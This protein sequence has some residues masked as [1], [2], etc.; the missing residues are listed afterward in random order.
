VA[1]AGAVPY[2]AHY[3]CSDTIFGGPLHART[4]SGRRESGF[5]TNRVMYLQARWHLVVTRERRPPRPGT[6]PG[7][8]VLA[9]LP[10]LWAPIPYR[11]QFVMEL[12]A[13]D[14]ALTDPGTDGVELEVADDERA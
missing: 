10:S 7:R 11:G 14:S 5:S 6:W 8:P 4:R 13:K 12:I 9:S 2:G 1:R 3:D